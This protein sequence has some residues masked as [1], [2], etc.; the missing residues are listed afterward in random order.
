MQ[1]ET[2]TFLASCMTNALRVVHLNGFRTI[3]GEDIKSIFANAPNLEEASFEDCSQ[4][5]VVRFEASSLR[6]L[7]LLA[8][9]A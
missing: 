5:N 9:F 8:V 1:K 6:R 2:R 7:S 3:H 4:I